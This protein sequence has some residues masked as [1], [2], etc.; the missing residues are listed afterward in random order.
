MTQDI[1]ERI[2]IDF[3]GTQEASLTNDSL[4]LMKEQ[5]FVLLNCN[6]KE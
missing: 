2:H 4:C 5:F 1:L 6:Y 3:L